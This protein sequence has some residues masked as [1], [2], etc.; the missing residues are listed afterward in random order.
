MCPACIATLAL[1]AAGAASTSGLAVLVLNTRRAIA[2]SEAEQLADRK[3]NERGG[4]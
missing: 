4:E 3:E 2:A 1:I